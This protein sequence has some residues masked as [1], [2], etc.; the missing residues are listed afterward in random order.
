MSEKL[1]EEIMKT[2]EDQ[3]VFDL[4][5]EISEYI[6]VYMQENNLTKTEMA[7]RLCISRQYLY[8]ILCGKARPSLD[9]IVHIAKTLG[10]RVEIKFV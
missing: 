10:K 1:F 5:I 4:M 8:E 7:N 9:L 2:V 3:S 6:S